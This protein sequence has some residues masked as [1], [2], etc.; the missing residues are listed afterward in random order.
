[1][2]MADIELLRRRRAAKEGSED[3]VVE[4]TIAANDFEIVDFEQHPVAQRYLPLNEVITINTGSVDV[5]VLY[6]QRDYDLDIVPSG[7][8]IKQENKAVRSLK[9]INL[10]ATNQA[11]VIIKAKRRAATIDD[12][13]R[14]LIP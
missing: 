1:M 13:I 8:V 6:N 11:Q 7:G 2:L 9:V 3:I 14:K 12:A 5:K 4:L 10:D